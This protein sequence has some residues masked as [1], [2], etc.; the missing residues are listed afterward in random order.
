MVEREFTPY[1]NRVAW[2]EFTDQYVNTIMADEPEVNV[3]V[4]LTTRSYE[5]DECK[6]VILPS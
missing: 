5:K 3:E 6:R 2:N 4:V 1:V